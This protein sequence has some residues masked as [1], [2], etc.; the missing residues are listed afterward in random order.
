[1]RRNIV[2]SRRIYLDEE[3]HGLAIAEAT[4]NGIRR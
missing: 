2:L 4:A 1:M 3:S